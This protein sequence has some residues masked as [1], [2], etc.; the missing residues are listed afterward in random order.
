MKQIIKRLE[1]IKSSITIDDEDIIELQVIKLKELDTDSGVKN[2]LKKLENQD[3]GSAMNDIE[4]YIKQHTGIVEYVDSEV[5]GLKLELKSLEKK[6]Q[7]L[8]QEKTE[9]LNDIEE[10]NTQYNIHLGEITRNILN[11]KKDILYK[12]TQKQQKLKDK[13][14]ED[15]QIY[16]DSKDTIEE[17]KESIRDLEELLKEIDE[18]DENYDE[19]LR[20]YNDLKKE[21]N[22]LEDDLINQE[23]ELKKIRENLDNDIIFKEYEEAKTSYEQFYDEYENIKEKQSDRLELKDE[24]IKELKVMWKKACRL[25]HPD[26]VTDELK[27]KANEIM[28]S[29]NDSYSR[30]DINKVK[31]IL[32]NLEN[33]LVFEVLS[34][35]ID[36]KEILKSKIEEFRQSI[37][38]IQEEIE[39]IKVDDTFKTIS[40]LENWDEYFEKLKNELQAEEIRLEN[41]SKVI[42]EENT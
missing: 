20:A 9:Y 37:I 36:N 11:L 7:S 41:E 30:R 27:E 29:L 25:C 40:N 35:K 15:N 4:N 17:I 5:I 1:I 2:I 12:Q 23:L 33:G 6:L 31:Q 24:D 14:K 18:N 3:Y 13:Y 32:L 19:I 16:Q 26:I 10:F 39:N 34:D 42:L 22:D 21:L 8:S 38:N 28:Q